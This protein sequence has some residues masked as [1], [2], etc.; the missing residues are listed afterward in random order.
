[1]TS[2]LEELLRNKFK[3]KQVLSQVLPQEVVEYLLV[4]VTKDQAHKKLFT[5][6][7]DIKIEN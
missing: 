5:S 6:N 1:M 3:L 7:E 4:L 2:E